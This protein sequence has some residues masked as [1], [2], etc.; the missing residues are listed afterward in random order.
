MDNLERIKCKKMADEIASNTELSPMVYEAFCGT[1]R[2][3]FVPMSK[4]AYDLAAQPIAGSQWISSPLTVA[5]MTMAL[6]AEGVD[7]V[8]EIG[9]GS[10]YQA[11]ILS[12]LAHRVFSIERISILVNEARA[13]FEK[14]GFRK[15][16][17]RHDDGRVG[18]SSYAPFDRILLSCAASAVP[19]RLFD[20]LAN[21]GILVAPLDEG[22]GQHI[23]KFIKQKDGN[24]TK[25]VLEPCLFVPLLEGLA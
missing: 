24:I 25:Q 2:E 18:W 13:R 19:Q 5:K 1:K 20:Q 7:K 9:C 22:Q 10:G 14:I 16:H 6:E 21:G 12:H 3:I 4:Y 11:A 15:I 23:V 8:L 17:L